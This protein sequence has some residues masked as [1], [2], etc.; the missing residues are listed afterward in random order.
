L[1]GD[2]RTYS[3]VAPPSRCWADLLSKA[4]SKLNVDANAIDKICKVR[5]ANE[6]GLHIEYSPSTD[7]YAV[8]HG[9]WFE[10]APQSNATDQEEQKE[11]QEGEEGGNVREEELE[12][13]SVQ[14]DRVYEKE[15]TA[16]NEGGAKEESESQDEE[17]A[18]TLSYIERFGIDPSP[19]AVAEKIKSDDAILNTMRAVVG[20]DVD[21]FALKYFLGLTNGDLERAIDRF[22]TAGGQVPKDPTK[23]PPAPSQGH[24]SPR[25]SQSRSSAEDGEPPDEAELQEI[26]NAMGEDFQLRYAL[27][28]SSQEEVAQAWRDEQKVK[29]QTQIAERNSKKEKQKKKK[30][31]KEEKKEGDGDDDDDDEFLDLMIKEAQERAENGG[32]EDEHEGMEGGEESADAKKKKKNKKKKKPKGG[33]DAC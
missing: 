32:K 25:Q 24:A 1:A 29:F 3:I 30:E 7:E 11:K 28:Q 13:I 6:S 9:D 20:E 17:Q 12:Q 18:A 33:G 4:A 23:P 19:S 26:L 21:D 14:V 8:T 22:F 15:G 2:I 31:R 5:T 16:G 27:K 10:I